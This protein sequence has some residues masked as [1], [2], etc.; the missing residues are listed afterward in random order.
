[1]TYSGTDT[2]WNRACAKAGVSGLHLHD[3]RHT[4]ATDLLRQSGNLKLVQ[5]CCAIA[6]LDQPCV[7]RMRM[8]ATC[9]RR[10]N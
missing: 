6:I 3:L 7:T 10:W 8:T 1:M 9:L 2:A 5:K 4:A